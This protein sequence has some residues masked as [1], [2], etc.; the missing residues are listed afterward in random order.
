M[1]K[2]TKLIYVQAYT[3]SD[4]E[5]WGGERDRERDEQVDDSK[6]TTWYQFC[7]IYT[8]STSEILYIIC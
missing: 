1:H 7:P 3:E 6:I 8:P 5:R 4:G 2:L